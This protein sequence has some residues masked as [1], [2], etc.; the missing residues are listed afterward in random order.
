MF[1]FLLFAPL[2]C[3][4]NGT[5][6]FLIHKP[7]LFVV[8][9]FFG[10]W[11][12]EALVIKKRL[13]GSPAKAIL[14]SFAVNLVTTLL[15]VAIVFIDVF[16]NKIEEFLGVGVFPNPIYYLIFII[17]IP[18][19]F[20]IFIEL[21]LFFLFYRQQGIRE[22]FHTT[23]IMNAQSY[24]LLL[25][26]VFLEILPFA[27]FALVVFLIPWCLLNFFQLIIENKSVSSKTKKLIYV[28]IIAISIILSYI[29]FQ[30]VVKDMD[31][32]GRWSARNAVRK[33]DMRQVVTAQEMYY[34]EYSKYFTNFFS[35]TGTPAIPNY[36]GILR[37]PKDT[38]E[39]ND[40]IWLDNTNCYSVGEHFCV[41]ATLEA[42]DKNNTKYYVAS[43]QETKEVNFIPGSIGGV[44]G[45]DHC[46]CF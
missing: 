12:I 11:I 34:G 33:S 25:L 38:K 27:T 41:Y 37:D 32:S 19:L 28:L 26:F 23:A 7:K 8:L 40:Y 15:G 21:L 5:I 16:S 22:L 45:A 29:I 46:D 39:Q 43:E 35:D 42:I 30:G 44:Y 1:G 24:L 3:K 31:N 20:S 4:A 13:G 6:G 36:L 17:L 2:L 14:S 18:L 9:L 10:V